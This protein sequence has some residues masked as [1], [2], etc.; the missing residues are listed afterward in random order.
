LAA[1]FMILAIITLLAPTVHAWKK[2]KKNQA[3]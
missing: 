3:A 1:G 2:G